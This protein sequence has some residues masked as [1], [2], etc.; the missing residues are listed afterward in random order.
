MK[1]A[2]FGCFVAACTMHELYPEDLASLHDIEVLT[3][4]N[5]NAAEG[6]TVPSQLDRAS[7]CAADGIL[8]RHDAGDGFDAGIN[9][10]VDPL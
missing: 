3:A 6:G 1:A 9:C 2:L 7:F 5:Y 10:R 8:W 4:H